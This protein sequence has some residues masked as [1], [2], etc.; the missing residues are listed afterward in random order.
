MD[1]APIWRPKE[2]VYFPIDPS[3]FYLLHEK[4]CSG[5]TGLK[6]VRYNDVSPGGEMMGCVAGIMKS[7]LMQG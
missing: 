6:I 2:Q 3:R 5:G 1:L 4:P 7:L